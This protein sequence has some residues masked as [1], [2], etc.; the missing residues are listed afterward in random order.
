M[1]L[2]GVQG[3]PRGHAC[4]ADGARVRIS[5]PWQRQD[6]SECSADGMLATSRGGIAVDWADWW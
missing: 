6:T 3:A 1:Q 4:R 5:G 2:V